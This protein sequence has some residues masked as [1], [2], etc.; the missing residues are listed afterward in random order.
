MIARVEHLGALQRPEIGDVGHRHNHRGVAARIGAHRAGV[1][2]VD[3]A[4]GAAHFDLLDRGL[5]CSG[6]RRHQRLALL[7]EMQRRPPRRAWT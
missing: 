3:V 5:Q 4:A 7:D 6:E 2:R 1:L